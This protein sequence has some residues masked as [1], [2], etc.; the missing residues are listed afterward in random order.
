M[1]KLSSFLLKYKKTILLSI[2][3]FI[4]FGFS[5]LSS[6]IVLSLGCGALGDFVDCGY[7]AGFPAPYAKYKV[8]L[9]NIKKQK[10]LL[11]PTQYYKYKYSPIL[12]NR[13]TAQEL[14][15]NGK[16]FPFF[17]QDNGE[18]QLNLGM[19]LLNSILWIAPTGFLIVVFL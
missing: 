18:Y 15:K 12:E 1:N 14:I 16:I 3:L 10:Q 7:Y 4:S 9:N 5:I 2:T 13:I 19:F 8:N 17:L 6:Y 11:N